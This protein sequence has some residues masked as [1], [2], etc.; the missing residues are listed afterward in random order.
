MKIDYPKLKLKPKTEET[1]VK[2]P[3]PCPQKAKIDYPPEKIFEEKLYAKVDLIPKGRI[4][5]K[6]RKKLMNFIDFQ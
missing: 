5:K 4:T 3:K 6:L 2:I 1:A